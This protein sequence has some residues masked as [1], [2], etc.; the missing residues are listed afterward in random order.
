MNL[1]LKIGNVI[2]ALKD[3][4]DLRKL[5][6][7]FYL[8]GEKVLWVSKPIEKL[9]TGKN[10]FYII[11]TDRL[12]IF[13]NGNLEHRLLS[14]VYFS[15]R[16]SDSITFYDCVG[17]RLNDRRKIL[18]FNYFRGNN[19]AYSI[20][21][22]I[23]E[24]KGP[25]GK[26]EALLQT[27]ME[28]KGLHSKNDI[29]QPNHLI[30]KGV[31]E[32]L[33]CTVKVIIILPIR[34]IEVELTCKNLADN[35]LLL[36]GQTAVQQQV[37]DV[38]IND[39]EFDASFII[40]S[41]SRSFLE[42]VLTDRT[43]ELMLNCIGSAKCRYQFGKVGEVTKEKGVDTRS[44]FSDQEDVLD[45]QLLDR[46]V[47]NRKTPSLKSSND[48]GAPTSLKL[49]CSPE[50][51]IQLNFAFMVRLLENCLDSTAELAKSIEGY[52]N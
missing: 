22:T 12:I 49:T 16:D 51:S 15:E 9:F 10:V 41:N 18:C 17:N 28:G 32:G 26:L 8:Q 27:S 4:I 39:P 40:Q 11:T 46:K 30:F 29:E 25:N 7:R 23:W 50:N 37:K 13:H 34:R 36:Y 14:S 43:K 5:L 24:E 35:F 20:F 52:N 45:F 21:Q 6:G 3:R 19:S 47:D 38:N 48:Q 33:F 2:D 1:P 44:Q 31:I 42:E